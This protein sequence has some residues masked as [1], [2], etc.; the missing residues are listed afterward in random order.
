MEIFVANEQN[1]VEMDLD[2]LIR[3]ARSVL[4]QEKV[5]EDA[6]LSVIC[7]DE[8][9]MTELNKSFLNGDYP[10]DVLAFPMDEDFEPEIRETGPGGR[11]SDPGDPP[12]LLGDVVLCPAV[13]KKQAEERGAPVQDEVDLLFVHGI[14]HLLGYDHATVEEAKAMKTKERKLL[15][16]FEK[17]VKSQ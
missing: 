6:D 7:L 14:L 3:L 10:T 15:D 4:A 5:N 8:L 12:L 17:T 2:R 11:L 16:A 9:A 13:A 1:E